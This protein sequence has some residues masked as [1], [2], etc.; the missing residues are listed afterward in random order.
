MVDARLLGGRR[1][2]EDGAKS[3]EFG[4]QHVDLRRAE[5]IWCIEAC[6]LEGDRL[7]FGTKVGESR[8]DDSWI[9]A[10]LDGRRRVWRRLWEVTL[11]LTRPVIAV[12]VL[13]GAIVT[14]TGQT[15]VGWLTLPS[16]QLAPGS[17]HVDRVIR[18]VMHA[19][20]WAHE[21]PDGRARRY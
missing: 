20:R 1:L 15:G 2:A 19:H 9:G 13:F 8:V 3:S 10:S 11:P 6:K 7:A 21:G 4:Q 18:A 16:P 12:A 14:F 5:A 17:H